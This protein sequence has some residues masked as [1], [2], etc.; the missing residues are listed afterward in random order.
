MQ[1]EYRREMSRSYLVLEQET[2]EETYAVKMLLHNHIRGL[3]PCSLRLLDGR[4]YFY[5]DVTSRQSIF[6]LYENRKFG[7][8]E[9]MLLFKAAADVMDVMEEYLLDSETLLLNPR[10]IYWS[11]E[12][13]DFS[14]CCC[15]VKDVKQKEGLCV[16]TEYILPKINHQDAEAVVLGYGVYRESMEE[17]SGAEQIRKELEKCAGIKSGET[18]KQEHERTEN[19][20]REPER[21]M[22]PDEEKRQKALEAFFDEEEEIE[23]RHPLWGLAGCLLTLGAGAVSI[24]LLLHYRLAAAGQIGAGIAGL[25][26]LGGAG[27]FMLHIRKIREDKKREKR[28]LDRLEAWAM[29]SSAEFAEKETPDD[30]KAAK[31]TKEEVCGPTVLLTP[32][33]H[34]GS[35]PYL[36]ISEDGEEWDVR[37]EKE[38]LFFGKMASAVDLCLHHPSVSRIHG[39]LRRGEEDCYLTDLN[40]KNGTLLNGELLV[41][42]Q[43]YLLHDRD[44]ICAGGTEMEYRGGDRRERV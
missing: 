11:S 12:L 17:N 27:V 35:L 14:F 21:G 3:L 20:N 41:P 8:E 42:E 39:K 44:I 13:H 18:K 33:E 16:L 24:Y 43:E 10:Y 1:T 34:R 25:L 22:G 30:S 7:S 31:E 23:E 4:Q 29:E 26:I 38:T 6:S 32:S 9:L 19:D 2:K 40:S 37:M 36:H 28:E 15:P 5:Y